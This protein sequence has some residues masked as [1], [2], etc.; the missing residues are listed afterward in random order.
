[1]AGIFLSNFDNGTI[2]FRNNMAAFVSQ[3]IS[4]S[5]FK[6]SKRQ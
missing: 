4:K 2:D 5:G 6:K 3:G 1:M